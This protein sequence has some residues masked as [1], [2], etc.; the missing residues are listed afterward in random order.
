[1][2]SYKK[3]LYYLA[4]PFLT[5]SLRNSLQ[6]LIYYSIGKKFF[7]IWALQE[8]FRQTRLLYYC[9][10]A[11]EHFFGGIPYKTEFFAYRQLYAVDSKVI[12]N[13]EVIIDN[14]YFL[15]QFSCEPIIISF[16]SILKHQLI[17]GLDWLQY[18]LQFSLC[19]EL[20]SGIKLKHQNLFQSLVFFSK[21]A[22]T[23]LSVVLHGKLIGN[24]AMNFYLNSILLF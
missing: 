22:F 10:F 9:F 20:N 21:T 8:F 23:L 4:L 12:L 19:Y 5:T 16:F 1:M 15:K 24:F 3:V 17:R 14:I 7:S 13:Y 2:C 11:R 18:I 6:A